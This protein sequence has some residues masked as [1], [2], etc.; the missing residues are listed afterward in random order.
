MQRHWR[1]VF[2][3]WLLGTVCTAGSADW[4]QFRGPGGQGI[5]SE[6]K[7]PVEWSSSKNIRWKTPLPGPGTSSP[8]TVGDRIY[9][10]YYTGYAVDPYA[11]GK[12]ENLRRHLVC[13]ALG[14]GK[15]LWTKQFDPKLP[16]HKYEGEGAYH[17]YSSSTPTSDGERL[18]VF[19]GKAGVYCFDLDGHPIWHTSVGDGIDRWGS[20]TSPVLFKNLVLINASVESGAI[21]ALDKTTGKEVW[22]SPGI[23]GAWNTPILV[24]TQ[25]GRLEL[26]V[27][28]RDRMLALDPDTG[29]ELWNADG[30]HRYVCP[31]AVVHDGVIYAIGGGHTSLAVR[32]GGRGDVTKTHSLWRVSKGSNV[33][34]PIYDDGHLYWASEKGGLLHCQN[35]ETGKFDY[36]HRLSPNPGLIY[37]SP[38]LADGKLYYVSQHQG[39]YVVAAQPKF[40]LLAHNTFDDDSSRTNA[41]IAAVNG[42]LLL[43]TDQAL[44]C[45]ANR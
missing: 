37:A 15:I 32:A 38:L 35:A 23:R 41:S 21:V 29:K 28:V 19:F 39:T 1:V 31:S 8:V 42:E 27:A 36:S 22:R 2:L 40:K 20:A 14:N 4:R 25:P 45:I 7:L 30:I 10:T 24:E 34:S 26:V 33:S 12:M 16:E 3:A 17:G 44:Y 5:S 6:K 18:F 9:L 13:V 43:R 11:P